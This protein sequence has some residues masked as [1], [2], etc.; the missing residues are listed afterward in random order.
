MAIATAY[1][2][3]NMDNWVFWEPT[4]ASLST[5]QIIQ[6]NSITGQQQVFTGNFIVDTLNDDLLGGTLFTETYSVNGITQHTVTG[7][8]HDPISVYNYLVTQ[9]GP[10]LLSYLFNGADTMN[11]SPAA[12][13]INGYALGDTI[14]G[15]NGNDVLNGGTGNDTLNGGAGADVLNGSSGN[16]SLNGGAGAD[17][18][19]G[20]DGNDSFVWSS[21]DTT[22]NGGAGLADTL[23]LAGGGLTLDLRLVSN[24][25]I[26]NMEVIN[27]TGTGNNH[28]KVSIQEV[29]DI[30][31]NSNTLR[32]DGN[33][34][35]DVHR[36]TG[37]TTGNDQVIG[38]NTYHRYTAP[39]G[40]VLLVDSD[41]TSLIAYA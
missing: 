18:L 28:L 26:Q 21:L 37:W 30:S 9:N 16:D 35:D 33:A 10:G 34:G 41:I 38:A 5:S 31:L 20:G 27:L 24:A 22:N 39:G 17:N 6:V 7:L 15:N 8:S 19:Q 32:V 25:K 36:G 13:V 29:L 4:D 1:T 3:I 12:D 2:A 40:A 11:G 14:N 23:R